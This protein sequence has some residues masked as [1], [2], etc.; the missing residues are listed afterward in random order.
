M[1][2]IDT[3]CHLKHTIQKGAKLNNILENAEK[4]NVVAMIDSPV[5]LDDYYQSIRYHQSYSKRIFVSAGVT[6]AQYHEFNIKDIIKKIKIMAG[7]KEIIAIGEVGLDYYWVKNN[8]LREKQHKAFFEFIDLA[9]ELQLPIVIHSRDAENEA[10]SD[11]KRAETKVIMHSFSGTI[12]AALEC[13]N[14]G[15]FISIPTCVTN[16]KKYR[17]LA[18]SIPIEKIL[19]ETDS[20]YLSPFS[21]KK[22]NEPANVIY[23]AKEIALLKE[24]PIEDVAE[25]TTKSALEIYKI[26]L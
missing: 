2:F 4:N 7:K 12:E 24:L 14:R 9:N 6:P 5:Y 20:P 13:V 3:H 19:I 22:Y 23:A 17:V 11:L 15:Y 8:D 25:A 21:E 1:R 26:S 18:K 10:I 16:R